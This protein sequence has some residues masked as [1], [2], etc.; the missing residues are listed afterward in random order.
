MTLPQLPTVWSVYNL[1]GS[2]YFQ[3]TLQQGHPRRTLDLFVGR[4][5]ELRQLREYIRG[6]DR[7]RQAV[8]GPSGVGKTTLV[9]RLK[10]A[11]L[12]DG[13]FTRDELVPFVAGD[14]PEAL[15]AR[16]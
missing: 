14:T 10:A 16:A 8:A 9:Q 11:T 13:Y 12:A 2:P 15:F 6:R 1:R 5:A 4:D 3:E 7:S